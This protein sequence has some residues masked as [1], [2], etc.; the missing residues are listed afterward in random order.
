MIPFLIESALLTHGLVSV[1]QE[2]LAR[3][4]PRELDAIAWVDGGKVI[5]GPMEAFLPFRARAAELCRID[6]DRLPAALAEGASGTLTASGTMAVC[7]EQGIPLAVTCGM[8][9]IGDIR[10][11]ELCP[12]LPALRDIPVALIATSPKDMLDIPGTLGWLMAAGVQVLGVGTDRCTG[13][14]FS[15]ADEPLSGA[16]TGDN[17]PDSRPLLLLNGIPEERRITDLPLLSQGVAAGKE[18]EAAGRAYHPAANAAFDRLTGGL[19]SRIQL[20]SL[21]ANGLLARR[22]T[23]KR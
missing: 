14:I 12:D 23:P 1:S 20:D 21:I 18:A 16:F 2:E 22:L 9:G 10:G 6:C 17:L 11:E 7:R 5:I 15:C 19:S 13:Y 4:W 3:R 8:G